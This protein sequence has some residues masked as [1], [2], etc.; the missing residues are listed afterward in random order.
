MYVLIFESMFIGG[1][2]LNQMYVKIR[3]KILLKIREDKV[4]K[5][6]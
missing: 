2:N 3:K 1:K 5:H 4:K 6:T